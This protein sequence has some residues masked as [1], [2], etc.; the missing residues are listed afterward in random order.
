MGVQGP[1]D[2]A[3]RLDL[4]HVDWHEARVARPFRVQ[5]YGQEAHQLFGHIDPHVDNP[6]HDLAIAGLNRQPARIAPGGDV[7]VIEL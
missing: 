4:R 1:D 2:D 5:I 7:E 3:V 6:A